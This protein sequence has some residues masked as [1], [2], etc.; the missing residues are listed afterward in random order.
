MMMVVLVVLAAGVG[1]LLAAMD[2]LDGVETRAVQ[3]L[4]FLVVVCGGIAF[5]ATVAREVFA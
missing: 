3:R 2:V 1:V 4:S 5:A